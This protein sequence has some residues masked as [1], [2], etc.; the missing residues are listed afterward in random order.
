M[1]VVFTDVGEEIDD[2][3][4][5]HVATQ[6]SMD[7]T[8]FFVCVPG[9]SSLDPNDA[10]Q[11]VERRLA[12]FKQLFPFL[13]LS[14]DLTHF[15]WTSPLGSTFYVGP[16]TMMQHDGLV[17]DNLIRI[18]PMWHIEP[19]Y[20]TQ[21]AHIKNYIAMGDLSQPDQSLN[22][23]KAIPNDHEELQTQYLEQEA[24]FQGNAD[25][26]HSIPTTLARQIPMP[27]ALVRGLPDCLKEPLLDTAF[28]QCVGR[29][30]PHLCFAKNI[31]VVNHRTILKYLS[32][33]EPSVAVSDE[34]RQ[35]IV[36]QVAHFLTNASEED[37]ADEAYRL[38]LEEIAEAVYR[39]TGTPYRSGVS[40]NNFD[41]D[42]LVDP[43]AAKSAWLNHIA[44][45][46]C[47]LTPCYDLLALV[48]MEKGYVPSVE[49]CQSAVRDHSK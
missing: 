3:V 15:R 35:G 4:M 12:R 41:K 33:D 26:I 28:E 11:E 24:V 38:R 16:P 8:W 30:P 40:F 25:M 27:Y 19:E 20:L 5:F 10:D 49:E 21:F 6:T 37:Q 2:E 22:L 13:E 1:N 44:K 34:I 45:H 31:S 48:V 42:N 46:D 17:V 39:L 32:S 7:S 43:D 9:A 29:V 36:E 14:P 23:T 47:D 18:A